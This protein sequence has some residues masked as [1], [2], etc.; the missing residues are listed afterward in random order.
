MRIRLLVVLLC[1]LHWVRLRCRMLSRRSCLNS[2]AAHAFEYNSRCAAVAVNHGRLALVLLLPLLL[3]QS[4][5]RLYSCAECGDQP[6]G[7]HGSEEACGKCYR[8]IG[9]VDFG[10]YSTQLGRGAPIRSAC[11]RARNFCCCCDCCGESFAVSRHPELQPCGSSQ[12]GSIAK[13]R[14][15]IFN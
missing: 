8:L 5:S 15:S 9:C 1:P 3:S 10:S 6:Q 11:S 4:C 7:C 2:F 14:C 12:S 13:S